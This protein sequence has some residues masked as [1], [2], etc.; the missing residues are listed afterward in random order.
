[1]QEDKFL[2]R[3]LAKFPNVE[4]TKVRFST[5]AVNDLPF[6]KLCRLLAENGRGIEIDA[7]TQYAVVAIAAS[8]TS[9]NEG[10]AA[11]LLKNKILYLYIAAYAKEGLIKQ[12]S[13][14]KII[15]RLTE[16]VR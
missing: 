3:V 5:V 12:H 7:E 13:T 6:L 11:I 16:L 10:V 8:P 14:E 2:L 4:K 1:M 15:Q 9:L